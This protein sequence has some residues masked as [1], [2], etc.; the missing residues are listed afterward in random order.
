MPVDAGGWGFA[1]R[2]SGSG[3]AGWGFIRGVRWLVSWS[4]LGIHPGGSLV[5]QLVLVGSGWGF[6]RWLVSW[7]W[8]VLDGDLFGGLLVGGFAGSG[9]MMLEELVRRSVGVGM[10]L[11]DDLG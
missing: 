1:G 6:I 2:S 7:S 9:V 4:W 10:V 5:G 3:R 11:A 8:L